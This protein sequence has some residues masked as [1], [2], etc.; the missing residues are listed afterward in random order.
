M[1][2]CPMSSSP[3]AKGIG[4]G[5]AISKVYAELNEGSL[6]VHSERAAFRLVLPSAARE[7]AK[8]LASHGARNE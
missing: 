3:K 6:Q 8:D 2:T 4:S 5:W 1:Q 7:V